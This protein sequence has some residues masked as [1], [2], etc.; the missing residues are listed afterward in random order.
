M[1]NFNINS[2]LIIAGVLVILYFLKLIMNN[3]ERLTKRLS[4]REENNN[5]TAVVQ[6]INKPL[7]TEED[8]KGS[9]KGDAKISGDIDEEVVAVIM[10]SVSE[11]SKI[12]LNSLKIKSIKKL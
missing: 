4:E 10:A 6:T 5:D 3:Q 12:P 11:Y 7:K 9:T 8:K 1:N 2:G